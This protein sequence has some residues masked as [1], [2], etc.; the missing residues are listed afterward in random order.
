M[1]PSHT[2]LNS[3]TGS[4][5]SY[6]SSNSDKGNTLIS[7]R[8]DNADKSSPKV[9]DSA[10]MESGR[11]LLVFDPGMIF[12]KKPKHKRVDVSE[13]TMKI[14][15]NQTGEKSIDAVADAVETSD[16]SISIHETSTSL[17][18]PSSNVTVSKESSIGTHVLFKEKSNH[19]LRRGD[20]VSFSKGKNGVARNIRLIK[21]SSTTNIHGTLKSIDKVND[22]AILVDSDSNEFS[23][24][25]SEI[26][27]CDIDVLQEN[28]DV[29]GLLHED[30]I[31]GG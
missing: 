18:N 27:S 31:Y 28:E 9:E 10:L 12:T 2:S 16:K 25:L 17:S 26:I 14:D 21:K 22:N 6:F 15:V 4:S 24:S 3:L 5:K 19:I 23:I 30:K 29:E 1:E 7:S 8:W 20:L 13:P 11:I